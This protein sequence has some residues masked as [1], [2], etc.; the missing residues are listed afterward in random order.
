MR[1]EFGYWVFEGDWQPAQRPSWNYRAEDGGGIIIDMFSH[2]NYVLENLF[3]RVESVSAKAVTHIPTAWDE[4]GEPYAATADDAAYGDL[5]ARGRRRRPD[6]LLWAVRVYRDEL[7]EFQVDGTHGSRR[8]RACSAAKIQPRNATPKPVWNPDLPTTHDYAADWLEVPDNDVFDNGFKLQWE[9]FLRHVV[10]DA[11]H[12][13]RPARRRPRRAAGRGGP[14]RAR[15]R[16]RRVDLPELALLS[17]RGCVADDRGRPLLDADGA[18]DARRAGRRA[19]VPPADRARCAQPGRLRRRARRAAGRAPTTCPG[20]PADID[21]DAT[22]A[23]RHHLWSCGLGVADAM[24][25]AQR[26]MGLD[27]AATRS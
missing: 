1:G 19:R 22:L 3:G 11:P 18:V 9:E 24:D 23:F 26:N 4:Q 6:Q 14:A 7:V 2:W 5:R 8:R 27:A 17:R 21:W 12:R 13:L 20:A 15:D 25:T 10:E 16:R